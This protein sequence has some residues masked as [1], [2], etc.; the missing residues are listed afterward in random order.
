[1]DTRQKETHINRHTNGIL[2]Y[3]KIFGFIIAKCI[4]LK[5]IMRYTF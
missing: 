4:K 3:K 2:I 1:M 5:K